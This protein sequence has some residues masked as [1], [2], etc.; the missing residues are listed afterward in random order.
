MLSS[1]LSILAQPRSSRARP[2]CRGE[3]PGPTARPLFPDNLCFCVCQTAP[4]RVQNLQQV[5]ATGDVIGRPERGNPNVVEAG[6]AQRPSQSCGGEVAEAP[7]TSPSSPDAIDGTSCCRK[8][9][10]P[11]TGQR[12]SCRRSQGERQED[13]P[14]TAADIEHSPTEF[15]GTEKKRLPDI[16]MPPKIEFHRRGSHDLDIQLWGHK[17][18]HRCPGNPAANGLAAI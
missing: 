8:A 3:E 17:A 1:D 11:D 2:P 16:L 15:Q 6:G 9:H 14:V 13:L 12:R 7:D 18:S 5:R 10:H 4:H